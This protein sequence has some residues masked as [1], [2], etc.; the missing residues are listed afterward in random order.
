MKQFIQY[1]EMVLLF[2]T[3][4]PKR[5]Y[6]YKTDLAFPGTPNA[7]SIEQS[8]EHLKF[9]FDKA[10]LLILRHIHSGTLLSTGQWST[11]EWLV[12]PVHTKG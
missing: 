3:F 8:T 4:T 5:K 1:S 7:G 9:E 6:L 2:K 12:T 11:A 10:L